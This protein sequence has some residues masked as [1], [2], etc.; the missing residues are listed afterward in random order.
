MNLEI[1]ERKIERIRG[2]IIEAAELLFSKKDFG[3]ISMKEIA[4]IA[5]LSRATLY[6]YFS[7]KEEIYFELGILRLE[8]M[9]KD[10]ENY[11]SEENSGFQEIQFL[12]ENLLE[13]MLERPFY[14]RLLRRFF[15]RS[16][17][18]KFLIEDVYYNDLI[19]NNKF[20][21]KEK[22]KK[23]PLIFKRL[24]EKYI[25]YRRLWQK[26]FEIGIK[27]GSIKTT[28]DLNHLNFM[29]IFIIQGIAEQIDY[30]RLLLERVDLTNELITNI[31]LKIIE[32]L[33]KKGI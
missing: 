32:N 25:E 21:V 31:T 11:H 28:L 14:S 1:K 27:D 29:I 19:L 9:I 18:L 24:L 7:S 16:K 4:D 6:N 8:E 15:T 12:S 10:L 23:H 3:K 30:R 26:A 20:G 2:I 5:A 13:L 33:I 17:E 22:Q